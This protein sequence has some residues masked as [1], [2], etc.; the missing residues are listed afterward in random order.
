MFF[1]LYSKTC[2]FKPTVYLKKIA[3]YYPHHN[4]IV[5]NI[6]ILN[7]M[8]ETLPTVLHSF[9]TGLTKILLE[10]NWSSSLLSYYNIFFS[11]SYNFTILLFIILPLL[12]TMMDTQSW[13]YL[14]CGREYI[15]NNPITIG[16]WKIIHNFMLVDGSQRHIRTNKNA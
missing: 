12:C 1:G 2:A 10:I 11:F 4:D 6:A 7:W 16:I 9:V 13:Q 5:I 14:F 3:A 15:Y 8:W